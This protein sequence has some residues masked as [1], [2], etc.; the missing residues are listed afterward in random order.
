M[1]ALLAFGGSRGDA[2]PGVLLARELIGRGHE[3]TLAV[4]PNLVGFAAEYGVTAKP[5]GLDTDALL[6][7]QLHDRG[8]GGPRARLRALRELNRQ[9]FAEAAEDLLPLADGADVVVG[10]MAN[11]EVAEGVAAHARAAFAAMHYFPI[12]PNRS[13]PIVPAPYGRRLPG[14]LNRAG[15]RALGRA[16]SWALAPDIA[17][18]RG[19]AANP[20]CRRRIAIQA[21]DERLFGGLAA[22]WGVD[23]PFVG[24]LVPPAPSG[25]IDARLSD[26]LAD[27]DAPV[28]AGFGSMPVGDARATIDL[29]HAACRRLGRRLLFATGWN[30]VEPCLIEDLAVVRSVD[31]AAVLPR[32]AVAIHHG[33]AGT[34]A[35]ALRA[36]TPSVVCSFLAD[37][38][39][40]GQ[41]LQQLGVGA[42]L[43]FSRLTEARLVR[44]LTLA[45][46]EPVVRR[47]RAFAAEFRHD[48]VARTAD[49]VQLLGA[50]LRPAAPFVVDRSML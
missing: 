31:H 22:E 44:L 46:G 24:F 11:E 7:A 25:R 4:S 19:R 23:H 3:V 8:R 35:A 14:V 10:A 34:T 42:T 6:R 45:T 9:G 1:R 20:D 12:R 17:E 48:G 30:A 27:G 29:V 16:R 5:F 47:S 36:G 41:R 37:Q 32:C 28:Y 49:V 2:Q 15:W 21:Y 50:G 13:V 26:W 33:G 18:L 39:Y 43:P 38:P 40:W